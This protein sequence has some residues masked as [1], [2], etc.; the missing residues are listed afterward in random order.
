MPPIARPFRGAEGALLV[1]RLLA[2]LFL[3]GQ[4]GCFV[5]DCPEVSVGE[6]F[7]INVV[8]SSYVYPYGEPIPPDAA[9]PMGPGNCDFGFDIMPGQVLH[10]TVVATGG[11]DVVAC[12]DGSL[13]IEPFGDWTWTSTSWVG[14]PG[15]SNVPF[16]GMYDATSSQC[17]GT[18]NIE[19]VTSGGIGPFEATTTG[20]NPL[21][22]TRT[23][24]PSAIMQSA[25]CAPCT[26]SFVVTLTRM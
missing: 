17:Q 5:E 8:R 16:G 18:T 15:T 4:A 22:M 14:L 19:I 25:T 7:A 11:G 2:G 24:N 23:F 20:P 21:V 13:A 26:G 6:K 3:V 12:R 9:P 10:A 1:A